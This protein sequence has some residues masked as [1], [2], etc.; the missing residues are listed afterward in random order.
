MNTL[1][2]AVLMAAMTGVLGIC[3][4]LVG[5]E[6]MMLF[7]LVIAGAG[8]LFAFWNADKIVL[9]MHNA[10]EV[11]RRGAPQLYGTVEELARRAGLP[12]PKVY[13]IDTAQP[14][15]FATGRNPD[16][17]AV[18]ATTGLLR[19]LEPR[20]AR[21]RHGARA[22]PC[23]EPR[24]AHHDDHRDHRGRG[25]GARQHRHVLRHVR[26]QPQQPAR[27]H[28]RA[29]G[30]DPGPDRRGAG[31]DGDLPHARVLRRPGGGRDLRQPAMARLGAREAAGKARR[32]PTTR[33]RNATRRRRTC[34]S[35]TRCTPT[36][37]TACSPPTRGPRTGW[38][39]W[40]SRPRRWAWA[41]AGRRRGRP[42]NRRGA[43][44]A[45]RAFPVTRKPG[46]WR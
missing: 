10:R 33:R 4:F 15:A 19:I 23:E 14:N 27:R 16:N 22:R 26:R 39:R 25:L 3:G 38:R 2:T 12:M 20:R 11:D 32:A 18:A 6:A 41:A 7:A 31:A 21:R 44:Q 36:R 34:S 43:G 5:G 17:A 46:P 28:R 29:A 9:R 35:S 1:R 37:W 30:D 24:H 8:N 42:P 13:V 40:W 45:G